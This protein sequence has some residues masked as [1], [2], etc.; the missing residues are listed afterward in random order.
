MTKHTR[1]IQSFLCER[2]KMFEPFLIIL[3]FFVPCSHMTTMNVNDFLII[4]T[5]FVLA[6][7]IL[8]ILLLLFT[9]IQAKRTVSKRFEKNSDVAHDHYPINVNEECE[10][11]S[12][13]EPELNSA[14]A[15]ILER[16]YSHISP[17]YMDNNFLQQTPDQRRKS[18]AAS[19]SR[20][21]SNSE[22]QAIDAVNRIMFSKP[23]ENDNRMEVVDTVNIAIAPDDYGVEDM[24]N[25]MT[26][27]PH[28]SRRR[29][30][31]RL[32]SLQNIQE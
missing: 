17:E 6:M 7:M 21:R 25:I 3:T 13:I 15:E 5:Y 32:S 27:L 28:L 10:C 30:S 31:R 1:R 24:E 18:S 26:S 29:R 16:L 12:E 20:S 8:I 4:L 22:Q 11:D 2:Y 14:S 23:T 19:V 9:V